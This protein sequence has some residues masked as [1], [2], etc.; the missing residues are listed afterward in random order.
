[1][2]A[3]WVGQW[4]PVMQV[5]KYKCAVKKQTNQVNSCSY[6]NGAKIGFSSSDPSNII[7]WSHDL[8]LKR[9]E[10]EKRYVALL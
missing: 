1:M 4:E 7:H 9:D 8:W 6:T 5:T 3:G 10:G 2:T